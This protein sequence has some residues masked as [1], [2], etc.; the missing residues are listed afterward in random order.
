MLSLQVITDVS[1][2]RALKSE[3]N[4]L[5]VTFRNP[6]YLHEWFDHCISAFGKELDLKIFVARDE[7][8]VRA[9]APLVFDRFEGIQQLRFLTHPLGEASHGFLHADDA[10]LKTVCAGIMHSGLPLS[11]PGLGADSNDLQALCNSSR[12]RGSLVV[13]PK[14]VVVA[15]V[16]LS[17]DW[18]S[19]ETKMSSKTRKFIRWA[20]RAAEREGPVKFDVVLP[21]EEDLDHYLVEAFRVESAGWKGQ[22]GSSILSDPKKKRF[23]QEFSRAATRLGI[24]RLFFLRIGGATVA[25]RMAAE[26]AGRLWDYKIG[27]DERW[28]RFSPGILL[29]QETL[30]YAIER[31]FDALEFLGQAERWQRRWPIELRYRTTI[32]FYPISIDGS[33]ALVHDT[34]NFSVNRINKILHRNEALRWSSSGM[35]S[36]WK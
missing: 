26:Y 36:T 35:E 3:W 7:G 12:V 33:L 32:R 10:S 18:K 25:M 14:S 22:A 17:D 15:C 21:T 6:L 13:R 27:Y 11:L 24:L 9:I 2:F 5:A 28:A 8:A 20:R 30:R 34:W 31:K 4:Q 29:T 16:R 19:I 1:E 23:W